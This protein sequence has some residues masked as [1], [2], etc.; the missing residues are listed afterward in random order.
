MVG[1]A[2]TSIPPSA[3][4]MPSEAASP[5]PEPSSMPPAT[6]IVGARLWTGDGRRIEPGTIVFGPEGIRALGPVDVVVVPK[7][8]R[9]IEGAGMVVTPGLIDT[10][11]HVGVYAQPDVPATRDGNE[12]TDPTTPEVFSEH[13]FWPQDPAIERLVAGGVTTIQVLPGSGN[14]IGGH[15]TILKLRPAL[16]ARAM[17]FPGARGGVK[18]ACGENPKRVYGGRKRAPMSR[19]G[20]LALL[21][22]EFVKAREYRERW[23]RH[24]KKASGARRSQGGSARAPAKSSP[25][26]SRDLGLEVL[27]EL[28]TG[29]RA[30]HIHCYRADE[31]LLMLDVAKEFGFRIA[32]FH[33]AVEAYK[34]APVLAAHGVAASVWADWWGFKL[35]AYDAVEA[36]AA[37]LARAG[38]RAV[39]H[40]DS[41]YEA[42]HL[43]VEAAK[44]LYAG[45]RLGLS[46][47]EDDAL[48]WITKNP[49][50]VLGIGARTGTLA[51]GKMADIVVWDR[52]P[53]SSY[54]VAKHVFIDGEAQPIGGAR[55]SDY[56]VEGEAT[57]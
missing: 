54:A 15:A 12:M 46:L 13:A 29:E 11:S 35:E 10:H 49:A 27:V 3:P 50:T 52:S 28:M 40:S 26:P 48:T 39:I 1:C 45:R 32:S 55:W 25:P 38:A 18:M 6:A 23:A 43:N 44:A 33:H 19:M 36:N 34:I 7:G 5:P 22:A 16:S 51:P 24:R 31:M 37:L 4:A 17:R 53:F 42:Q 56:E 41:P 21:R 30:A 57:R 20:N 2:S 47:S 8:A 14:L 9:V